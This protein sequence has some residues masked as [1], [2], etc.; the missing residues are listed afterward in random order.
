MT[1]W[2]ST[3]TQFFIY[4]SMRNSRSDFVFSS[5]QLACS[6][7]KNIFFF[8][9]WNNTTIRRRKKKRERMERDERTN[10]VLSST[11]GMWRENMAAQQLCV[12]FGLH[13][14]LCSAH[15]CVVII[16]G[17]LIKFWEFFHPC[18]LVLR[19]NTMSTIERPRVEIYINFRL[20]FT[21]SIVIIINSPRE[22]LSALTLPK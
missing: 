17:N 3:Y 22:N 4:N 21:N 8:S 19:S 12:D 20:L 11:D 13:L 16:R 9:S 5:Q 2:K 14:D 18:F 15:R 1:N 6:L 10:V 7:R